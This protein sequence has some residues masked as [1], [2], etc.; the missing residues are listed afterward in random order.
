MP[1]L[2]DFQRNIRRRNETAYWA[3]LPRQFNLNKVSLAGTLLGLENVQQKDLKFTPYSLGEVTRDFE[4]HLDAGW[5]GEAGFDVKYSVTPG[6]T[7]DA[8]FNTDFAQVEVDEQQIN[9]D[10]FSL[11]FP[12]KRP[13]F[14]ENAGFFSIGTP[15]EVELFFSR[16]IGI[17]GGQEVP[18]IAGGRL[19]GKAAGFNLG[20]LT[21]QTEAVEFVEP[22]D[23]DTTRVQANNFAVARLSKELPNR[24]AVGAIFLNRQGFGEFAP[25]HDYNR[26]LGV[27]GRWGIGRFG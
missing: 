25:E 15:Q 1:S 20:L 19:S 18:I 9:L 10:R 11:F 13:F 6:L 22:D 27:D 14:L 26:T 2:F 17:A 23:G 8:S 12:E 4:H 3:P 24:S 16:R 21:M 7:L 5:A